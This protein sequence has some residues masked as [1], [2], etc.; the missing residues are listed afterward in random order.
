MFEE[1]DVEITPDIAEALY[2][3]LATDT[4]RF[5]YTNTSAKA[6]SGSPRR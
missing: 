4:G 3:A 6:M 1:L 5:Q 2:I